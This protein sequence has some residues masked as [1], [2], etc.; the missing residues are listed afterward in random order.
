[1]SDGIDLG[2]VRLLAGFEA[3][4]LRAFC[5]A[6][7]TRSLPA[8]HKFFEIGMTNHTLY[9]IRRGSVRVERPVSDQDIELTVL[10]AGETFGEMSI[11]DGS[12]T[13]ATLTAC[14]PTEVLV[15]TDEAVSSLLDNEPRL[16]AKFFRNLAL[17]LK[18]RL[19]R[20]DELVDHY[21]DLADILREHPDLSQIYYGGT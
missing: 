3:E 14:E 12:R 16:A 8:G 21:V 10:R 18:Q 9:V 2:K 15:I 7:E 6:A 20:T 1:M 19:A 13:T 4:E 11:L 5:A 17:S